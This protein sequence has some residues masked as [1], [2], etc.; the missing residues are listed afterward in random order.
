MSLGYST[1]VKTYHKNLP[2]L[3]ELLALIK[4]PCTNNAYRVFEKIKTIKL[5]TTCRTF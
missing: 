5:A 3:E 1:N 2:I 4:D